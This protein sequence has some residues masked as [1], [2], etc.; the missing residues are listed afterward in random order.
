MRLNENWLS[1]KMNCGKAS[2]HPACPGDVSLKMQFGGDVQS[3]SEFINF[4]CAGSFAEV[5]T[6]LFEIHA[7]VS[8][9][10]DPCVSGPSSLRV[11]L[12]SPAKFFYGPFD[13]GLVSDCRARLKATGRCCNTSQLSLAGPSAGREQHRESL[14]RSRTNF[15]RRLCQTGIA[16]VR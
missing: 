15:R 10:G 9:N 3:G 1:G 5:T 4:Y 7:E 12:R 6:I 2:N 13:V 11:A 14:L 8:G 16:P